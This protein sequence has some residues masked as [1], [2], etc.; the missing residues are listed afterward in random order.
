[1]SWEYKNQVVYSMS[2]LFLSVA[3]WSCGQDGA[4]YTPDDVKSWSR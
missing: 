1:M 4:D 2:N 3:V